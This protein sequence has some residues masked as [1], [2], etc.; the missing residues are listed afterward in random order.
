MAG[1][2][3]FFPQQQ[4]QFHT[5]QFFLPDG[6]DDAHQYFFPADE[7]AEVAAPQAPLPPPVTTAAAAARPGGDFGGIG[8]NNKHSSSS[9]TTA[10]TTPTRMPSSS[11]HRGKSA[12][13]GDS[14]FPTVLVAIIFVGAAIALGYVF[15]TKYMKKDES[16]PVLREVR[17]HNDLAEQILTTS[18]QHHENSSGGAM[19]LT[20]DVWA[21][22]VGPKDHP[23]CIVFTS[24]QCGHCVNM[25]PELAKAIA[26]SR[27]APIYNLEYTPSPQDMWK[28]QVMQQSGV[29]AFPTIRYIPAGQSLI[30]SDPSKGVREFSGP[31]VEAAL[32]R[33]AQSGV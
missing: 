27:T 15:Y 33:F 22:I 25:K 17:D 11:L 21:S 3:D 4:H 10:T 28:Q 19:D 13:D 29:N 18:Q 2:I 5:E 31:R 20:Q 26:A 23:R 8:L 9:H 1:E 16:S 30:S 24:A 6:G 32:V 7:P 12:D 14:M